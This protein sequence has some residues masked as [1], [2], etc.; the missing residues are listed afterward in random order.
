MKKNSIF[1]Q[2][3]KPAV[4]AA[5]IAP[6]IWTGVQAIEG[7]LGADPIAK[8]LNRLGW[9]TLVL[10]LA[11]LACTPARI[12]L[13]SGWPVRLRRM[14]GL[15]A[16]AYALLH[17]CFYVGVDQFF[18]WKTLWADVTRR[19]F[20]VVGFVALLMLIPLAVTSTNGMIR[21]LGSRRWRRLHQLVYPAAVLGVIHF[22]WRVKADRREPFVFAWI[23]TGLFAVRLV[24]R[25]GRMRK[26]AAARRG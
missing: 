8:V 24:H 2:A 1:S 17:F 19:K 23:L 18:D 22:V 13:R 26:G 16:F 25:Y 4:L 5:V 6:L 10:L 3:V 20:M 12:L 15:S 7:R 14:L 11:S 9:W 21:R